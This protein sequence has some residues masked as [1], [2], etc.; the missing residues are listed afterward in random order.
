MLGFV[1]D[2]AGE[3]HGGE[4]ILIAGEGA[5]ARDDEIVRGEIGGRFEAIGGMVDEGAEL[6]SEASGF[7]APIFEQGGGTDDEAD[8]AAR[9]VESGGLSVEGRSAAKLELGPA[10]VSQC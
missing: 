3:L 5:V 1:G 6:R 4:E 9:R 7:A 2:D 10:R 8:A